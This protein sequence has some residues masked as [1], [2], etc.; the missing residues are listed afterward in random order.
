M[1]QSHHSSSTE[2][3]GPTGLS[4][5][6]RNLL[7]VVDYLGCRP[8]S[9]VALLGALTVIGAAGVALWAGLPLPTVHDEFSYLLQA[10]TFTKG[11]VTNPTPRL[12]QHFETLHVIMQPTYASKYPPGQGLFLALGQLLGHPIVGVWISVGLMVSAITWMLFAWIPPRW[13]VITG[14]I[15]AIHLGVGSYWAHSYWGGGVAATGGALAYG[16]LRRTAETPSVRAGLVFGLGLSLMALSRPFEGLLISLPAAAIVLYWLVRGHSHDRRQILAHVVIP[17]L[18][19]VAVTVAFL[20]YY[21][22]RVTGYPTT[23]PYEVYRE[24]YSVASGWLSFEVGS[25]PDYRHAAIERYYEIWGVDRL[26]S[27]REPIGFLKQSIFKTARN[28]VFYL[29]PGLVALLFLRRAA[30]NRWILFAALVSGG[31]MLASLTTMGTYPHYVAPATGLVFAV[32]GAALAAMARGGS[33]KRASARR[34]MLI[35]LAFAIYAVSGFDPFPTSDWFAVKRSE[36]R[37]NLLQSPSSD[38]VFVRYGPNHNIHHEW[39][40]NEADLQD[41]EIIW[42]RDMGPSS[43]RRLTNAYPERRTW[44]LHVERSETKLSEY[45]P[46]LDSE[47]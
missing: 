34:T 7:P 5:V 33:S 23:W 30:R 28:L 36:V 18:L 41:A 8:A 46:G 11:R 26:T 6:W 40:Y 16:A 15:A 38:L 20:G 13:A 35:L 17:S 45:E 14:L 39:V 22:W 1:G 12:W 2:S 25:M 9:A 27:Y 4:A 31:L 42:A 43:N 19:L 3:R 21:N 37:E 32:L 47:D 24:E 10:D 29:G 44:L